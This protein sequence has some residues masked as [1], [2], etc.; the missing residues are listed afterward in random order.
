MRFE[1]ERDYIYC[2]GTVISESHLLT[3]THCLY[4]EETG[5]WADEIS[6][7]PGY[8]GDETPYGCM[9]GIK[10]ASCPAM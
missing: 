7:Y 1:G 9:T 10:S 3:A 4:N 8:N 2:T 5:K 6:F